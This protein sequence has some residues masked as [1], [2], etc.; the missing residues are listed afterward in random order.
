MQHGVEVELIVHG[1]LRVYTLFSE[2]D[3]SIY[4]IHL[5][6]TAWRE[7]SV[8]PDQIAPLDPDSDLLFKAL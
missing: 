5:Q 6:N 2:L 3:M 8:D 7:N 4:L 1:N